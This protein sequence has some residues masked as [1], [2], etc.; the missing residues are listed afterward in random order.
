MNRELSRLT[1]H[2]GASETA[3]D[4]VAAAAVA[5]LAAT[6]GLDPP[7]VAPGDALPPGWHAP[8]FGPTYGPDNMRDDGQAAHDG[9]VPP[10]P[11]PIRRLRGERCTFHDALRIGDEITRISELAAL[12]V[13]D[14]PEV[15]LTIRQRISSRRGLA[16]VEEREF[17]FLAAGA[18]DVAPAPAAPAGTPWRREIDPDPVL[19]FRY[20]A[21]RFNSHRIHF[22]RD[23]AVGHEGLAGLIVHGTLIWQLMLELCRAEMPDRPVAEFAYRTFRPIYDTG[24]FTLIGRPADDGGTA[25]LWAID[26]EGNVATEAR[27][28]LT[29]SR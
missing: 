12:T 10:V 13:E 28:V 23:Y 27:A 9:I 1:D 2:I 14:G 20:S 24:R 18:S 19:L 11:L 5:R 26:Q 17:F 29:V 3:S 15:S 4:T 22:D 8:F 25:E 7:A 16:V 21:V 6:L